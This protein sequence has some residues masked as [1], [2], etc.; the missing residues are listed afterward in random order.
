MS[1]SLLDILKFIEDTYQSTIGTTQSAFNVIVG[2]IRAVA[3]IGALIYIFSRL[4]GQIMRSEPIDFFPYMRP[5]LIVMMIALAPSLCNVMDKMSMEFYN[6]NNARNTK[7]TAEI[8]KIEGKLDQAVRRKW[9]IKG[10]NPQV[11]IPVNPSDTGL[12][13][14]VKNAYSRLLQTIS[15]QMEEW[16]D[17][18][19]AAL[20]SLIQDILLILMQVAEAC[21]YLISICYRLILR[22]AAPIV[23]CAAI[24]PGMTN[25]LVDWFAKYINFCLMPFVASVVSTICFTI[26]ENYL[27]AYIANI[28]AYIAGG[29]SATSDPTLM[30]LSYIGLLI[31]CLVFYFQVPSLTSLFVTAGGVSMLIAGATSQLNRRAISPATSMGKNTAKAGLALGTMGAGAVGG[32]AIGAA[33]SIGRGLTSMR[34]GMRETART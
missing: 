27:N 1:T 28:N 7:L 20:L 30:G 24:F 13:S 10:Q 18:L 19:K 8:A 34:S 29:G 5:F 12:L 14:F 25:A 6:K 15:S 33:G 31:I 9:E 21:L 4:A 26:N 16:G 22:L 17:Y 32:A 11:G 2:E 3:G 23:F